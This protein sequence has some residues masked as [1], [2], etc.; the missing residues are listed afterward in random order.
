MV[1][2]TNQPA[3]P[4]KIDL[5]VWNTATFGNRD[6]PHTRQWCDSANVTALDRHVERLIE[7]W[8]NVYVSV[9]T[10]GQ[11]P[12]AYR[13]GKPHVS[14]SA[15][16]PRFG[17][18]L[19]DVTDLSRLR[20]APTWA[21]ETSTGNFQVGYTCTT[22][23]SPADA[24]RL[25]TG[26]ALVERTDPSGSDATQ[27]IRVPGSLNT[28]FKCL[29]RAGDPTAG[30]EPEGWT[31]R[32]VFADGPR[33]TRQ[34][35]AEAF[36]P[37]G[38]HDLHGTTAPTGKQARAEAEGVAWSLDLPDGAAL[39]GTPRYRALFTRR[40]QLAALQRGERVTLST[41][42]GLMDTGSEQVAV[43]VVNLL[44]TGIKV[45]GEVV[46]GLGAPPLD[47][48]RA[49]ALHWR[50]TLRP[51]CDLA[52]Y[53]A[54]VDRLIATYTP[55]RYAPT[56][57]NGVTGSRPAPLIA[58]PPSCQ[59]GRPTHD[60]EAGATA[61]LTLLS[62]LPADPDGYARTSRA[63]LMQQ[64][65]KSRA[66]IGRYL[67]DLSTLRQIESRAEPRALAV[68]VLIKYEPTDAA[69]VSMKDGPEDDTRVLIKSARVLIK[70]A[71]ADGVG[72]RKTAS[73]V[74][75]RTHPPVG[76]PD[77]GAS[78]AL[79]PAGGVCSPCAEVSPILEPETPPVEVPPVEAPPVEAPPARRLTVAE[80]VAQIDAARCEL[81]STLVDHID[82]S[83]GEVTTER[84]AKE[85][86]TKK[87]VAAILGMDA[88]DPLFA[89]AWEKAT[90]DWGRYRERLW[91]MEPSALAREVGRTR[92]AHFRALGREDARLGFFK[93]QAS[94]ADEVAK[95]RGIALDAPKPKAA[96]KPVQGKVSPAPT[97]VQATPVQTALPVAA[98]QPRHTDAPQVE[99]PPT[100]VAPADELLP[101]PAPPFDVKTWLR[102]MRELERQ[103]QERR[104]QRLAVPA[105]EPVGTTTA[106]EAPPLPV[107]RAQEPVGT[108]TAPV[109]LPE[110][111]K[112]P[113]STPS[114][115]RFAPTEWG[116]V[117]QVRTDRG[118]SL[119]APTNWP[120]IPQPGPVDLPG[121]SP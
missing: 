31:V 64:T 121:V 7:R 58:L 54:D 100:P 5:L 112:Q 48:I 50:E 24:A 27:L 55:A 21:T 116:N 29:G 82:R 35:L 109:L 37:G 106:P 15:P 88:A 32:L 28:K 9:G 94:I 30:I 44:T 26:A 10:Y 97:P 84:K 87:R 120:P 115:E 59:R 108:T 33:Y 25:G 49:V 79:V 42:H 114:A 11:T 12:N 1:A 89:R 14:R 46:P 75:M 103:A 60:R 65:G 3:N 56:A 77:Q 6:V 66:T 105:Q 43:L 39:M 93:A 38:L 36:L 102:R 78:A 101:P 22:I 95:R 19:D 113:A 67:D 18:V 117:H 92:R 91:R 47:E 2:G 86:A 104:Q 71:G 111:P 107:V 62:R 80:V 110:Q 8:G 41:E 13:D 45:S 20:L 98:L 73:G 51:G 99:V 57:T 23:L 68:R 70:S 76:E 53:T 74:T 118:A 52:R 83:T 61:L 69:R 119:P 17:V 72:M 16:L 96:P 63:A 81:W 34:Q 4:D 85:R 40:P 90:D